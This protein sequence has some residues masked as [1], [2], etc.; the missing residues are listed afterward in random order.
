[1]PTLKYSSAQSAFIAEHVGARRIRDVDEVV[2]LAA[3][4]EDLPAAR[5]RRSRSSTF[6]ITLT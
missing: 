4:A 1:M 3:V 5:R 2:D 6:M